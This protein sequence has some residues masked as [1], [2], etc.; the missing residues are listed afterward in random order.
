MPWLSAETLSVSSDKNHLGGMEGMRQK[1]WIIIT[2]R[3]IKATE[4]NRLDIDMCQGDNQV[5]MIRYKKP[6]IATNYQ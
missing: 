2:I 1:L 6:K 3:L 4:R 5:V